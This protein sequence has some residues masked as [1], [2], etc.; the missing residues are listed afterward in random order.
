MRKTEGQEEIQTDEKSL[1]VWGMRVRRRRESSGK[2]IYTRPKL[3]YTILFSLSVI[4]SFIKVA[5]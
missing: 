2:S 5:G 1:G 3:F 4:A